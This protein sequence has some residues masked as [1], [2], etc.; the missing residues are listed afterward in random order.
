MADDFDLF[1]NPVEAGT[2]KPGRPRKEATKEDRNKIKMLLA[3]GWSNERMARVMR[4]SL[5]TF[6]RNFFQEMKERQAARDMLDARRIE[7]AMTL[8]NGGNVG[9]LKELGKM[10]EKSDLMGME[11][12]LRSAQGDDEELPP[13]ADKMV[14]KKEAAKA[15]AKTAG[16]GSEWGADLLPGVLN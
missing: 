11:R 6:R 9:A 3:F 8:A 10:L 14:G 13:A 1:G 12:K 5:P 2:G 7:I 16:E 15:A 4:M